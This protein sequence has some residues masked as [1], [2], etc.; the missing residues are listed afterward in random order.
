MWASGI[1]RTVELL[2]ATIAL[3][4]AVPILIAAAIAIKLTSKGPLFFVQTRTGKDG[5]PFK[6]Y[7]LRTMSAARKHDP[8]EIVPLD[9]SDITGVGRLLRRMKIDELPQIANVVVGDMSLV[10]P[11]P[12][13]PEQTTRY[14][15]F[16]RNRLRVRP[17]VTG[18][19]QVNGNASVPWHERIKYDVYYVRNHTLLM[20][21]AIYAKTLLVLVRGED[22]YARPFEQSPYAT[23]MSLPKEADEPLE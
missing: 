19:A 20:D 11:R 16:Q 13:I 21:L 2:L 3:I 8:T 22:R 6:A 23:K 10:G 7:K 1:K 4:I 15:D 12:T 17:G 5:Q 18:L 9:H 14:N